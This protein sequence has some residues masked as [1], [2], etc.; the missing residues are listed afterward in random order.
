[1]S[2]C[3]ISR[4]A[5][6]IENWLIGHFRLPQRVN[7]LESTGLKSFCDSMTFQAKAADH[8]LPSCVSVYFSLQ[9]GF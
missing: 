6:S 1:M 4:V 9:F 5:P 7:L 3:V 8:F 2:F